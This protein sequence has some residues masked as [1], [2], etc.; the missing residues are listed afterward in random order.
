[1]PNVFFVSAKTQHQNLGDAII[2]RELLRLASGHGTVELNLGGMPKAFLDSIE[3]QHY[4]CHGSGAGF[5]AALIGAAFKR[6]LSRSAPKVYYLLNPGGF[7]G[8]MSAAAVPRHLAL[9]LVYALLRAMGVRLMRVGCSLGPFSRGRIAVERMKL[10]FQHMPSARDSLSIA[11]ARTN[12]LGQLGYFPDLALLLA[13]AREA[14]APTPRVVLSF[15]AEPK[16]PGYDDAVTAA[17]SHHLADP[18][19]APCQRVMAS[20]VSFD[21]P[22]SRELQQ[23]FGADAGGAVLAP[24]ADFD[25][26]CRLYASAQAVFSNRLHVLLFALRQGVPTYAVIDPAVNP[27]IAGI[28]ADLGLQGHVIDIRQAPATVPGTDREAHR[29][30]LARLFAEQAAQARRAFAE[31][32]AA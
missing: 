32:L 16:V 17:L 14:A 13:E 22:R 30:D 15:R 21:L 6:L 10:A 24:E 26:V 28:F 12:G 4:R 20:Q 31:R 5:V 3:A 11:Y 7:G 25:G 9:V 2:T 29:L 19:F 8:G 18:R 27:K 23:V 1:M